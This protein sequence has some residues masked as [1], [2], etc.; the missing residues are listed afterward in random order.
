MNPWG[1]GWSPHSSSELTMD[2]QCGC[3]HP[4]LPAPASPQPL[5]PGKGGLLEAQ[6]YTTNVALAGLIE[7]SIKLK[8]TITFFFHSL[9]MSIFLIFK[10]GKTDAEIR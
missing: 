5:I 4:V 7:W 1:S 3:L 10:S 2:E 8:V 9:V 6:N